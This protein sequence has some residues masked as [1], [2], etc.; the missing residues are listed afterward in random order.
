MNRLLLG[1]SER[2]DECRATPLVL[3]N[4]A[5]QSYYQRAAL[6]TRNRPST[7]SRKQDS[8][9]TTRLQHAKVLDTNTSQVARGR[10]IL[11]LDSQEEAVLYS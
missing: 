7:A 2:A 9:G 1:K 5:E 10:L 6:A 11:P 8:A 3:F 4:S